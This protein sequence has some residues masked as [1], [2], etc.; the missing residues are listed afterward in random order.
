MIKELLSET[1]GRMV[2]T[3]QA[4]EMDLRSVR[5]GRASPACG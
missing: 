1:Q 4:L 5:T 3:V 2:K